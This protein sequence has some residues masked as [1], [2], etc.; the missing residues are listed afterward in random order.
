M[1]FKKLLLLA[2]FFCSCSCSFYGYAQKIMT[3]KDLKGFIFE[4]NPAF[5]PKT[6][7]SCV[8]MCTRI[9]KNLVREEKIDKS[10]TVSKELMGLPP[11]K[12]ACFD[13][14]RCRPPL[15]ERRAYRESCGAEKAPVKSSF[16]WWNPLTWF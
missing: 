10:L 13:Q 6:T 3:E 12:A 8:K 14:C 11:A 9:L 1:Q 5:R 2:L 15:G 16:V 7:N 4:F